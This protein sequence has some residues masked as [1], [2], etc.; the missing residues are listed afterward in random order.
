MLLF[1]GDLTGERPELSHGQDDD[2]QFGAGAVHL[3]CP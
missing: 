1:Y 2:M 3:T